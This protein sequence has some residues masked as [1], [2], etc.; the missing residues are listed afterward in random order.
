MDFQT[1]VCTIGAVI[2]AIMVTYMLKN[3]GNIEKK[4]PKEN[5]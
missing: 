4:I 5:K 2:L 1:T 3:A